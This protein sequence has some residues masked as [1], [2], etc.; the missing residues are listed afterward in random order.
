MACKSL[1]DRHFSCP[2]NDQ[3]RRDS[4]T[5]SAG[6]ESLNEGSWFL[7]RATSL[8][9]SFAP[10]PGVE[11]IGEAVVDQARDGPHDR[12]AEERGEPA[13]A[14]C[15]A[16]DRDRDIGADEKA[17]GV[18]RG[19]EAPAHVLERRAMGRERLRLEIDVAKRDRSCL[20]RGDEPVALAIDAGVADGTASIVPDHEA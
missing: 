13:L 3:R 12:I 5:I 20:D 19:M 6:A 1:C 7:C 11:E 9:M 4:G 18:V 10:V 16:P 17:P 8:P 14:G 2:R 15:Q